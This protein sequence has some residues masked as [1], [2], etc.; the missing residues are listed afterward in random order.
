MTLQAYAAWK[1]KKGEVARQKRR[2][3]KERAREKAQVGQEHAEE[4]RVSAI[5]VLYSNVTSFINVFPS[6]FVLC[7]W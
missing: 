5:K 7:C 1:A 3:E 4:N 2:E 6:I